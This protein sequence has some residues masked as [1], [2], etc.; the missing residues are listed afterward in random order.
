[1]KFETGKYYHLYNRS[2]NEEL[3]YREDENYLYF[4]QRYREYFKQDLVT[5]AYCLM[6]THFH[7]LIKVKTENPDRL[8][9][10]IGAFLS[11]YTKAFNLRYDRHGSMFQPRTK[12]KE[13]GNDEYLVT[14][15]TYIHQNP[16][17]AK[18]V[19]T[20]PE[21]KYS[22]YLDL[23]GERNGNLPDKDFLLQ[24]FKTPGE[25]KQYSEAMIEN[26]KEE[27]WM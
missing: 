22:S 21:W 14:L 7:F 10:N 6:P 19:S 11:G 1:M 4:L 27:Y 24:Y 8:N 26:I 9:D 18:L 3:I 20:Q 2:N 5:V 12:A 25:Y 23:I 17:R 15:I 16:V 13:V